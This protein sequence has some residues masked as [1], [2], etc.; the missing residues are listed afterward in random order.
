MRKSRRKIIENLNSA[1]LEVVDEREGSK[2]ARY[3]KRINTQIVDNIESITAQEIRRIINE[4]PLQVGNMVKMFMV[5]S[6]ISIILKERRLSR[7]RRNQLNGIIAIAGLYGLSQVTSKNE[8]VTFAKNVHNSISAPK[9]NLNKKGASYVRSFLN[10]NE[11]LYNN[12]KKKTETN[13][14]KSQELSKIPMSRNA[15]K[16]Y[17]EMIE[18]DVP[19]QKA[20]Y[21][22]K[23]KYNANKVIMRAVET[24]SNNQLET[25]KVEQG[26]DLGYTHKTWFTQNDD[27]VR[28]TK[29]HKSVHN[30]R[31]PINSNFRGGG[32]E[33]DHPGDLSLK[34]KD[35]I[36]C[37]CY[38]IMS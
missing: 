5:M 4:S 33:G 30:K 3:I 7:Q 27:R 6:G 34:P 20:R 36:N 8:A 31:V 23:R 19:I 25:A 10:S 16:E 12:I 35:R 38:L 21:R 13:L 11:T 22:L 24:E 9:S 18:D 28:D 17:K 1:F 26:K 15:L 37:R 32:Q 2:V 14:R 29:F